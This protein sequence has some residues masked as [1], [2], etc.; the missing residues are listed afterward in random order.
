MNDSLIKYQCLACG[1]AVLNRRVAHCLYCAAVLPSEFLLVDTAIASTPDSVRERNNI[2]SADR[3][4]QSK[5]LRRDN[6]PALTNADFEDLHVREN[7]DDRDEVHKLMDAI[8]GGLISLVAVAL[9][10]GFLFKRSFGSATWMYFLLVALG[11]LIGAIGSYV[12]GAR[13]LDRLFSY[14]GRR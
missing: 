10:L 13:F 4:S 8:A 5:V 14:F 6:L 3:Q 12:Y 11:T 2:V 9:V 7:R 1:K